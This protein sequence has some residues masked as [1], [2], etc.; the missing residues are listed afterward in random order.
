MTSFYSYAN[1]FPPC[2]VRLLARHKSGPSMTTAEIAARSNLD[3]YE[4][5]AISRSA[6]WDAIPFSR[7]KAFLLACDVDFC[8]RE[9]M[10][11]KVNYLRSQNKFQYL[12]RSPEWE[13]IL[14]PLAIQFRQQAA[15]KAMRNGIPSTDK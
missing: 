1:R 8:N 4:V 11:R 14:R 5:D 3:A 2:L 6:N 9:S 13:T 12:R 7:M 15:T 10:R